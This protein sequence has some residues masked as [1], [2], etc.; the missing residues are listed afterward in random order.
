MIG[1]SKTLKQSHPTE[2][3]INKLFVLLQN[4][5]DEDERTGGNYYEFF[6]AREKYVKI[7]F[8][9]EH[10]IDNNEHTLSNNNNYYDV[11]FDGLLKI[12]INTEVDDWATT[13]DSREYK[14]GY[15]MSYH[16]VCTKY[17]TTIN[18]LSDFV[19]DYIKY[20]DFLP[21]TDC[22]VYRKGLCKWRTPYS[23]KDGDNK[24][25]NLPLN[26]DNKKT[27]HKHIIQYTENLI[28]LDLKTEILST[29]FK[30]IEKVEPKKMVE[31][32]I[33]D[34]NFIIVSRKTEKYTELINCKGY[35]PFA[36]KNHTNNNLF[37]VVNKKS[38]TLKC[39]SEQCK[40][41][42]KVLYNK[43]IDINYEAVDFCRDEFN[44][45]K[46]L[47]EESNNYENCKNYF[48]FHYQYYRDSDSF[49]R[50]DYKYNIKYDYYTSRLVDI[51]KEGLRDLKY[52]EGETFKP[53]L[54]KYMNDYTRKEYLNTIFA[55]SSLSHREFVEFKNNKKYNLFKGFSYESIDAEIT[56]DDMLDFEELKNYHLKYM[57]DDNID[58]L[59]YLYSYLAQIIQQPNY[60]THIILVLYSK[61][62]GTGKSN[63]TKFISKIIGASLSEF[64]S[65]DEIIE[66][67]SNSHVGK[68]LNTIEEVESSKLYTALNKIKD[69]SQREE[70]NYNAKNKAIV[71]LDTFVRYIMCSNNALPIEP[72]DRRYFVIN[73]K[74][75]SCTD[76]I[77]KIDNLYDSSKMIYLFGNFLENYKINYNTRD[78]WDK[79]RP[80][81]PVY[82]S[83]IKYD[84]V[85]EFL[86]SIF[87]HETDGD[88]YFEVEDDILTIDRKDLFDLYKRESNGKCFGKTNFYNKLLEHG[89]TIERKNKKYSCILYLKKISKL[90]KTDFQNNWTKE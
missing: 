21:K 55:P 63:F 59:N 81:T 54:E 60:L 49:L 25:L 72:D 31:K 43:K 14:N 71:S 48:E 76:T 37:I 23:Q 33:S 4:S 7:Y 82:Y 74:K 79:Q 73:P 44:A 78:D 18:E 87:H 15:K 26:F 40:N 65:I 17:K 83:M 90:I 51:K 67:H 52:K 29:V 57:C 3:T 45:I 12:F 9:F 32:I 11:I 75:C 53:F 58:I 64:V 68:L 85:F 19:N 84:S 22:A 38:I 1:I 39:H 13:T 41:C 20:V 24:S 47:G 46:I 36:N 30:T 62:Q 77:K 88:Y 70:A 80:L 27:F 42:F 2:I 16:F 6:N 8:D 61:E 28:I 34:N 56:E 69:Y 5:F 89:I 86:K 50:L 35:C 66:K 10:E